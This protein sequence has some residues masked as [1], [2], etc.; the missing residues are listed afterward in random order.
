MREAEERSKEAARTIAKRRITLGYPIDPMADPNRTGLIGLKFSDITTTLGDPAAKRT[1]VNPGFAALCVAWLGDLGLNSGDRVA[2]AASG[3]FPGLIIAVLAAC[4]T[5]NMEPVLVL[6]LGSSEYGANIPELNAAQMILE[7]NKAGILKT[8]PAALSL[9]GEKDRGES[10][11]PGHET[12]G[13]LRALAAATGLPLLEPPEGVDAITA[14]K[15]GAE[16]R[17]AV[18][19]EGAEPKVFVNIGGGEVAFG[20][21]S[22]SLRLPN[23]PI[24]ATLSRYDDATR[25]EGRYRGLIFNFLER[26][27]PVI[28]FLD[29]KGMAL[30]HGLPVDP[31][32]FPEPGEAAFYRNGKT[33][34]LPAALGLAASFA[35]LFFVRLSRDKEEKGAP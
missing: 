18:Y 29:I 10:E 8:F 28:H 31:V 12:P 7:L 34:K 15:Q 35:L 21:T 26:G 13:T 24:T 6:S 16:Q 25:V 30:R 11:F 1:S 23:G 3:S 20:S 9:G 17:L 4:E 19:F 22:A 27:I 2:I 5:L 14:L 32:P 33:S